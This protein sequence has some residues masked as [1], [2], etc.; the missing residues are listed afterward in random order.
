ME[1]LETALQTDNVDLL[2]KYMDSENVN[3][4]ILFCKACYRS[5]FKC[6]DYLIQLEVNVYETYAEWTALHYCIFKCNLQGVKYLLH[7]AP[8]LVKRGVYGGRV[9]LTFLL[10]FHAIYYYNYLEMMACLVQSGARVENVFQNMGYGSETWPS[11]DY[12]WIL[13]DYGAKITLRTPDTY[14]TLSS[15]R[16]RKSTL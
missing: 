8:L 7:K 13:I 2:K 4:G 6:S 12:A 11:V 14:K 5:A 10:S 16:D 1:Y 9:P 15:H 3:K